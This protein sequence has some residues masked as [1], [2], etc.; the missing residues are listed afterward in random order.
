V[1]I[2]D[3]PELFID[4]RRAQVNDTAAEPETI[5]TLGCRAQLRFGDGAGGRMTH[6]SILR[7][8]E[9]FVLDRGSVLVS[10]PMCACTRSMRACGGNTNYILEAFENGDTAVT[11]LEGVL[12]VQFLEDGRSTPRPAVTVESGQRLR[13]YQALEMTTVIDLTPEDY[14]GILEGPFF[15]GFQQRL[16]DQDAL[17]DY[18][19]ENV[20]GVSLP[21][22]TAEPIIRQPPL[23]LGPI[24]VP[25]LLD[26]F[27][28]RPHS[29][30][31]IRDSP[32]T[33]PPPPSTHRMDIPG[34]QQ[35]NPPSRPRLYH[36]PL[37]QPGPR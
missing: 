31:D 20:P 37:Q 28:R 29:S 10:G 21:E 16:P 33:D 6:N 3:R 34:L 1:E 9:C 36:P 25:T 19:R 12:D 7:L 15:T 2:L 18:L 30:P 32:S 23:N 26:L 14:R 11:S 4:R 35:L 27:Q 8:G 24:L 13:Q 17:E 22:E 5:R